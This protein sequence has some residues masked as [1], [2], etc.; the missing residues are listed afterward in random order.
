MWADP[1]LDH[2]AQLMRRVYENRE[3]ARAIGRK[4]CEDIRRL[5]HPRVVGDMI[6]QRLLRNARLL[7]S[8]S[9]IS[10]RDVNELS[11]CLTRRQHG[12]ERTDHGHQRAGPFL[13]AAFLVVSRLSLG[14]DFSQRPCV[15][16]GHQVPV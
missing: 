11:G 4:A 5:L 2:A 16:I 15:I 6:K 13:S 14:L 7:G 12:E 1:D 8:P 3:E 10:A 9:P